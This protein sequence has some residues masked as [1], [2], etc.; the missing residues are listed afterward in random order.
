[1]NRKLNQKGFSPLVVVVVLVVLL[2]L[3]GV[4]YYV[5]QK[6]G[7]RK[8]VDRAADVAKTEE[9]TEPKVEELTYVSE[10]LNIRLKIPKDWKVNGD[11]GNKEQPLVFES[12]TG[13]NLHIVPSQGGKGGGCGDVVESD[14]PHNTQLCSTIEVLYKEKIKGKISPSEGFEDKNRDIYLLRTKR[15]EARV[16][17]VPPA[18]EYMSVLSS[19]QGLINTSEPVI[20]AYPTSNGIITTFNKPAYYYTWLSGTDFTDEDIFSRED[21]KQAEDILRSFEIM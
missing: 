11:S 4:G 20:G 14:V 2:A 12:A 6:D 13:L 3:G 15:T 5:W 7:S 21:V 1:M 9:K 17:G 8:N 19:S 18:S 16:N 10:G